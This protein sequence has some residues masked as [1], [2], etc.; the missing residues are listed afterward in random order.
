MSGELVIQGVQEG[1][2]EGEKLFNFSI[3]LGNVDVSNQYQL[4]S[5][6]T[7][8]PVP[9]ETP[10]PNGVMIVLPLSNSVAVGYAASSSA[11]PLYI[12]KTGLAI[13]QF[14]AANLPTNIYLTAGAAMTAPLTVIFF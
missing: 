7:A 8:V 4:A 10:P 13:W 5:G 14:D 6:V 11:T 1:I 12:N 3:P 2:P 9:Q